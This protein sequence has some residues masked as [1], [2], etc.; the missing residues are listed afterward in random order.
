[1]TKLGEMKLV[2]D[3]LLDEIKSNAD[4]FSRYANS[5]HGWMVDLEISAIYHHKTPTVIILFE[6]VVKIDLV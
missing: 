1:V 6:P 4:F 3:C 2:I 5:L